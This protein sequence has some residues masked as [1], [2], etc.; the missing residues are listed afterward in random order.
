MAPAKRKKPV[1]QPVRP[2]SDTKKPNKP[3]RKRWWGR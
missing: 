1:K 3:K 2:S